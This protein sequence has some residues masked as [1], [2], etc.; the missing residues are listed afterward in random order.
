MLLNYRFDSANR[1]KF[2]FEASHVSNDY[3]S[4][5]KA[6]RDQYGNV[7]PSLNIERKI[8]AVRLGGFLTWIYNPTDRFELNPGLRVDYF[9]LAGKTHVSP[10]FSFNYKFTDR[11]SFTGSAGVYFQTLPLAML[12]VNPEF[13]KLR[14]PVAYHYI[15]GINHLLTEN[16]RLTLEV[17]DKE[18]HNFPLDPAKPALFVADEGGSYEKLTDNGRASARGVE[19]VLQKK[20]AKD[21]YGLLSGSL[22]Q[23]RYRGYDKVWRDRVFGNRWLMSMEGGYI[24]SEKWE[25]SVRWVAAG[26]RPYTPFDIQESTARNSGIYDLSRINGS[27]LPAYH[28]LNFRIDRR[29]NFRNSN[30]IVFLD[31]W[32]LYNRKN[33]AAYYWNELEN[34]RDRYDQWSLLPVFGFEWEF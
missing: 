9:S 4:Y 27:R 12:S 6:Y 3:D 5:S 19:L 8:T 25:Y 13:E 21:F 20:L 1:I 7:L 11:T 26:G 34:Q 16:T 24:A 33:L 30:L 23:S 22:Y 18:Y 31:I 28:S 15:A 32:N 10:R 29:F 17:Y 14:D 2:G